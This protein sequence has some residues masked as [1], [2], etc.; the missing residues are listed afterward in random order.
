M[1]LTQRSIPSLN[2][3]ANGDLFAWD[4]D[5]PG[6]GVRVKPSGHKSYLIQYREGR[7][8]RRVTIGACSLL[9][10]EQARDSARR[11][12]VSAKDGKGPAAERDAAKMAS[13]VR[14]FTERYLTEYA[15]DRKK[16][17]SVM[18]DR[19]NIENH[20]LPLL[21]MRLVKDVS[22]ADIERFMIKVKAGAT[23]CDEKVGPRA[24]RIVR[25]G[26]IAANR[27]YAL[28]SKM[29]NLA[30]R[31]GI[32]PDGSNPCRHV[33]RNR[34]QRRD[35]FLSAEELGRL[36][37]ALAEAERTATEARSVIAAI[38]LLI[39]TGA[40]RSEILTARWENF[41]EERG[42]LRL[43]ESKTGAKVIHLNPP[44]LAILASLP[45]DGDSPWIVRA[46]DPGRP[47][48][49]LEKPWQRLRAC[50]G[51]PNVRLHDLRHSF[52]SIAVA[53]GLS[54]PMI[55][56]LLGHSQPSTTARYAHLAAEPLRRAAELVGSRIA[57]AMQQGEDKPRAEIVRAL[58]PADK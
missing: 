6:F 17:R 53:D 25:G 3:P 51:L 9:K 45:R 37:Q 30:E 29:M 44:A 31:W 54:L 5:L 24:R 58:P 26:P 4:D 20:V 42:C 41:D 46:R 8:T 32:R 19:R 11:M 48:A 21:G 7:R 15:I 12:L 38:R 10:L 2:P 35:R 52:A 1:K 36:E 47:V 57:T 50:A 22:R 18:E 56:A 39:F 55:G 49:D 43:S 40:R 16:P 13:T 27:C 14:E 23:A 28:L 34:E 33:E